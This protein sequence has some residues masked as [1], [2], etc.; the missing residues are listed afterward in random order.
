MNKQLG[1][2][3]VVATVLL[4][5]AFLAMPT[6]KVANAQGNATQGNATQDATKVQGLPLDLWINSLKKNHPTLAGVEE[7]PKVKDV[8]AKIKEMK[9]PQEVTRNLEALDALQKLLILKA[10]Q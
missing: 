1:M 8:I 9:D 7:D 5:S 4:S 3:T 10:L 6:M 2:L